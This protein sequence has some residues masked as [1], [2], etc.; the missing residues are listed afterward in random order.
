[1]KERR[2]KEKWMRGKGK[3]PKRKRKGMG[4]GGDLQRKRRWKEGNGIDKRA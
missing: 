4:N 2:F 1:M 3:C